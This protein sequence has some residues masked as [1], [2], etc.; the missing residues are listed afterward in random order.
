MMGLAAATVFGSD[1]FLSRA[2][3][4]ETLEQE[5]AV[6]PLDSAVDLSPMPIADLCATHSH[7]NISV[8]GIW[9]SRGSGKSRFARD[10]ASAFDNRVIVI[11][12]VESRSGEPYAFMKTLLSKL[13]TTDDLFR[14]NEQRAQ[15]A[16]LAQMG[17][18]GL[19]GALPGVGFLLGAAGEGV[20]ESMSV[21][22]LHWDMEQA[23]RRALETSPMSVVV[24]SFEDADAES[25]EYLKILVRRFLEVPPESCFRL[26]CIAK[27]EF[28]TELKV[29]QIVLREFELPSLSRFVESQGIRLDDEKQAE[30]LLRRAKT[31][32]DLLE[33]LAHLKRVLSNGQGDEGVFGLPDYSALEALSNAMPTDLVERAQ[34]RIG[35]LKPEFQLTL[36]MAAQCGYDFDPAD[37]ALGMGDSPFETLRAL[38]QIEAEDALVRDVDQDGVF[39]FESMGVV[40]ALKSRTRQRGQ[41]SQ[42]LLELAKEFHLVLAKALFAKM[43]DAVNPERVVYHAAL[44]GPRA[45]AILAE[46]LTCAA[47]DAAALFAWSRLKTHLESCAVLRLNSEQRHRLNRAEATML[48]ALG[49][50][51]NRVQCRNLL[52]ELIH[53]KTSLLRRDLINYLEVFYEEKEAP[54]LEVLFKKCQAFELDG[55]EQIFATETVRFYRLLTQWRLA[56]DQ[57]QRS[58]PRRDEAFDL[59]LSE[60]GSLRL[61]LVDSLS[62]AGTESRFRDLLLAR[63]E[64][65]FGNNLTHQKPPVDASV[66]YQHLEESLRLAQRHDDQAGQATTYGLMGN[67]AHFNQKEHARALNYWEQSYD[68]EQAIRKLSNTALTK[69]KM[70]G[71][72][73][74]IGQGLSGQARETEFMRAY[75]AAYEA[76]QFAQRNEREADFIFAASA[77]VK[78]AVACRKPLGDIREVCTGLTNAEVL[79]KSHDACR[80]AVRE[81]EALSADSMPQ[82]Y[83]DFVATVLTAC[84]ATLSA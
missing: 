53:A 13:C 65:E 40:E 42:G 8:F 11:S 47:E 31:P 16:D 22:R 4:V 43:S 1:L 60:L 52:L 23:V 6:L 75:L 82:E 78:Y 54:E 21:E 15:L 30:W 7:K 45:A 77:L 34:E 83:E 63:V 46:A 38:R 58:D 32:G 33:L 57:F 17:A 51:E 29:K 79:N 48:R 18:D 12:T 2:D 37:V 20:S 72:Y 66:I 64:N 26:V 44:A 35:L 69:N 39:S 80:Q 41:G 68:L 14:A 49:G 62:E 81:L 74:A 19:L 10:L 71:A 24:D 59:F 36:E 5:S 50:Q 67:Y 70:A 28:A 9:G 61:E 55:F 56:M 73:F 84:Q 25:Q 27:P 3:T 76:T